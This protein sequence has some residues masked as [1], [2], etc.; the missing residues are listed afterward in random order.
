[1]EARGEAPE[2]GQGE[3]RPG[4]EASDGA[5]GLLGGGALPGAG[6]AGRGRNSGGQM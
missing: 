5:Q 1:M 2:A 4:P 3:T 6:G